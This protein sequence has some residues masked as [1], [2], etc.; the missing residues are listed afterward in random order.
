[1]YC[2]V[3]VYCCNCCSYGC[4]L[5]SI[6]ARSCDIIKNYENIT[7]VYLTLNLHAYLKLP[8]TGITLN[9]KSQLRFVRI[10]SAAIG[11]TVTGKAPDLDHVVITNCSKGGILQQGFSLGNFSVSN[12]EISFSRGP[13][14]TLKSSDKSY[15]SYLHFTGCNIT[16]NEQQ[17]IT[18]SGKSNLT[19]TKCI[20]RN[21]VATGLDIKGSS[22]YDISATVESSEISGHVSRALVCNGINIC[23]L[24][25]NSFIGNLYQSVMKIQ[26]ESTVIEDNNFE[27][28]LCNYYNNLADIGS[29]TSVKVRKSMNFFIPFLLLSF[30][31][32]LSSGL[33]LSSSS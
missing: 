14:V 28:N 3:V 13:G 29:G 9:G 4:I 8:C 1:V 17:G 16:G 2:I 30:L 5:K 7:K 23:T 12:S 15:A 18:M 32:H 31:L 24:R 21:N 22:Y 26:S 6:S 25:N 10:S 20:V 11:I 33:F 27:N 19:V